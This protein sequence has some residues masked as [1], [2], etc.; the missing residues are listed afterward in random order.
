MLTHSYQIGIVHYLQN[1]SAVAVDG[2]T[3]NNM[4]GPNRARRYLECGDAGQIQ[5]PLLH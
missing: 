3:Q 5:N 4:A 2:F 1:S